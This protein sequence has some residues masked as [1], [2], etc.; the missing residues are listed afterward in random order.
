MYSNK[1][2]SEKKK[3]KFNRLGLELTQEKDY[4]PHP[5]PNKNGKEQKI[6][7]YINASI[8]KTALGKEMQTKTKKEYFSQMCRE[9]FS[10]K[11]T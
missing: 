2:G 3:R 6:K 9:Y 1:K 8:W 4:Y 5:P 11:T 10:I 7:R